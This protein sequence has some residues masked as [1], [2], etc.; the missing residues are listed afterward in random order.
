MSE[1][2]KT[3]PLKMG[4]KLGATLGVVVIGIGI[5]RY[6]TGM[7]LRGDQTLS[8]VYWGIF[9]SAIFFTVFRFKKLDPLSF[10]L[11]RTIKIGLLAGL[12]SGGMYT[13]YIV[14]LNNYVDTELSSE[15]VRFNEQELTRS[16]PTMS[17]AE[18]AESLRFSTMS[19][20][21]RGLIYTLV[22]ISFGIT[23]SALGTIVVKRLGSIRNNKNDTA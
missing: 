4:L 11:N 7:I 10:S 15:I 2:N 12:L 20:A 17:E 8:L 6:K 13:I 14:I 23:Y 22:C 3:L 21:V 18:V 1:K 5:I 19:S 9:A 16:N